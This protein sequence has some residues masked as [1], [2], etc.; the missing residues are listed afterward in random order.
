MRFRLRR[1][2]LTWRNKSSKPRSYLI[3]TS[4]TAGYKAQPHHD[5]IALN[6]WT[7]S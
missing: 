2:I 3:L 6:Y 4:H 5:H 1:D 7:L